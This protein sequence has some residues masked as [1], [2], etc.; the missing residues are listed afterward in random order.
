MLPFDK[1]A[2]L[3]AGVYLSV[4]MAWIIGSD[5]LVAAL[6]G[7]DP[8]T[9]QKWQTAKGIGFVVTMAGGIYFGTAWVM[10]RQRRQLEELRRLEEMLQVSQ[11]LEALGTLAAT[12]VHDFNNVIGVI[13][14][15]TDLARIE[16]YDPAKMPRRMHQQL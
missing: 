13:R 1:H 14:G 7:S 5:A 16:H 6:S 3:I 12:V 8:G 4:A 15:A 2:A 11:R 10:A 9:L